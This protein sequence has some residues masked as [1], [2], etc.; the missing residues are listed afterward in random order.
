[1]D[2]EISADNVIL[3][4]RAVESAVIQSLLNAQTHPGDEE[5]WRKQADKLE[6]KF[7]NQFGR[8]YSFYL[9]PNLISE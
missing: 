9:Y 7:S 3:L 6:Q 1:M 8:H 5:K 4:A 2:G